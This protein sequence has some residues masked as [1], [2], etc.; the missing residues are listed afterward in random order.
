[1]VIVT[2]TDLGGTTQM[3]FHQAGYNTDQAHAEAARAGWVE[4]FDRR[5]EHLARHNA[6]T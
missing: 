5:A 2:F 6:Y 4:F 3:R 1:V